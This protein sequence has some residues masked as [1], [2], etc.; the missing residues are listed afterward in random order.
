DAM[1]LAEHFERGGEPARAEVHYLR[2][3]RQALYGG[4]FRAALGRAE[5]GLACVAAGELRLDLLEVWLSACFALGDLGGAGARIEDALRIAPKGSRALCFSLSAKVFLGQQRGDPG[6][7]LEVMNALEGVAPTAD[8]AGAL[9]QIYSVIAET[10][11]IVG[12]F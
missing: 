6:A 5:K 8:N 9:L 1:V 11:V 7:L 2:A 12:S 4:D 3:S 10:L